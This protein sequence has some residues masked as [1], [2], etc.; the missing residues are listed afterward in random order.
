MCDTE[1]EE[2]N[3]ALIRHFLEE[4]D[5]GNN[6]IIE[7][8]CASDV[9]AKYATYTLNGLEEFKQDLVESHTALA[10]GIHTIDGLIAE[11]DQVVVRGTWRA[12]HKG[13]FMGVP[14]TGKQVGMEYILWYRIEDG[15][16]RE[17]WIDLDSMLGLMQQIG[18]ELKPKEGE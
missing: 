10:D 3:K 17:I 4:L 13:E 15:K 7:E 9:V 11:N 12:T 5:K 6:E 2:Q 16:I 14:P 1:I 8:L 18:M